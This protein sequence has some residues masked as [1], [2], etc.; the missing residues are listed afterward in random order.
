MLKTIATAA[1]NLALQ[2]VLYMMISLVM[3]CSN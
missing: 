3:S 2:I 1:V